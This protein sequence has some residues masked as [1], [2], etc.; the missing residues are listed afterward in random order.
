MRPN[1][2]IIVIDL[3][4]QKINSPVLN[5]YRKGLILGA[6]R[7][8]VYYL[9]GIRMVSLNPSISHFYHPNLPGGII[10]F[11]WP[12]PRWMGNYHFQR[13]IQELRSNRVS[14]AFV[15][16]GRVSH[17]LTD[18]ACPVHAQ[19]VF[20]STDPFE[21][22]VEAMKNELR[23]LE[24]AESAREKTASQ[25]IQQMAQFTQAYPAEKVNNPWG[26]ALRKVGARKTLNTD[27]VRKQVRE[28]IPVVASHTVSLFKLFLEQIQAMVA[29]DCLKTLVARTSRPQTPRRTHD[30]FAGETPAPPQVGFPLAFSDSLYIEQDPLPEILRSLEMTPVGL[31]KWFAQMR[32]F[33][34]K[35]GGK[36]Y[37]SEILELI[38]ECE[39]MVRL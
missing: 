9:P 7:E 31:R 29:Q 15:Q 13:A 17:L 34:M 6:F 3:A 11:L 19:S 18:M 35:H 22:A 25:L 16:L 26:Y 8:N 2:F 24:I 30:V 39:S 37:Y 20:H 4:L 36:K 10:P 5:K 33:C 1:G 38:D 27:I 28:L 12:G 23:S 21:W 32:R 14:A